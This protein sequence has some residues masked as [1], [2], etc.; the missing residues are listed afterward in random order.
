MTTTLN[1]K[2]LIDLPEWR[3]I[4]PAPAVTAAGT[5][6]CGDL[7]G[8]EDRDPALYF[9][10]ANTVFY[11]YLTKNDEWIQLG[12]PALLNALGAGSD[13]VFSPTG[14]TGTISAGITTSVTLSTAL[15]SA[16]AINQLANRGD[17]KGY[18]IR[19][20]GNHA[21]GS[22]K[23]EEAYI[24]ANT[25]G[26]QPI[27]YLDRTLT[28]TPANGD[29]YE[30]LSGRV[31]MLGTGAI[32][33]GTFKY[34]DVATNSYSANLA[35]TNLPTTITT[36]SHMVAT[37]ELY[38]PTSKKAGEGFITGVGTYN[39]ALFGCLTATAIAAG[40]ITGQT[41]AG[42]YGI[43][44]NE[45][46]NFQIRIV[47]DTGT[48]TAVGQRRRITS[49]TGGA[50]APVYTLATN[51]TVTPS[52]TCKYVLEYYG[53]NILLFTTANGNTYNYSISGNAWDVSTTWA[54]RGANCGAGVC[55]QFSYGLD[56]DATLNQS[57]HS[58]LYSV[59]GGAVN[60]IDIFDI[61]GAATGA[62]TLDIAYGNKT[63]T[64]F[65]TGTTSVY[66]PVT[67]SGKYIYINVNGTQRN[68]RFDVLNRVM[69][70]YGY[71]DFPMSTAVVGRHIAVATY[72]DG[73]FELGF[74]TLQRNSGAEA[75][76]NLIFR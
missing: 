36:D 52:A 10:Q 49:H 30:F 45:Y 40:T 57:R 35:T 25:A 3:P 1:F 74:I 34:Y 14:P 37:P 9:L 32:G 22:G 64:T 46:R 23:T 29:A 39:N 69:E 31:Y 70:P 42:D 60:S 13:A 17:G 75:F 6:I 48:P 72:F 61:A 18:K 19:I 58:F 67:Q 11:K 68:V 26:T 59:R 62:W 16:V 38:N 4:A 7:R 47:E 54:V 73:T 24:I 27:I 76:Q 56:R 15:P 8:N 66:N 28:F 21:V 41:A 55:G 5:A 43:V 12:S 44:A 63:P 65:T 51:W 20:I 71:L 2:E 50:A 33:A 53:D